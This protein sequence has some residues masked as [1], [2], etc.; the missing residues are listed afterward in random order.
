MWGL[1]HRLAGP[2]AWVCALLCG[3]SL[4]ACS[5]ARAGRIRNR[6]RCNVRGAHR[7]ASCPRGHGA[8]VGLRRARAHCK[9]RGHRRRGFQ[10][11]RRRLRVLG[12]QRGAAAVYSHGGVPLLPRC[13]AGSVRAVSSGRGKLPRMRLRARPQHD[14]V[15]SRLHQSVAVVLAPIRPSGTASGSARRGDSSVARFQ[16]IGRQCFGR[17]PSC[18]LAVPLW[19][20]PAALRDCQDLR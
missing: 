20:Q 13:G 6:R 3:T 17:P 10:P 18:L 11:G 7:R 9:R 1:G 14:G 4:V 5:P 2:A 8:C 19:P 16:V 12:H 15:Q